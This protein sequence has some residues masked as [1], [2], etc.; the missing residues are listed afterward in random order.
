ME[1]EVH[2]LAPTIK[3]FF[4]L[5]NVLVVLAL[6]YFGGRKAIAAMIKARSEDIS[7]KIVDAKFE[8]ERIEHEADKARQEIASMEATRTR[9][10]EEVKLEGQ[11]TYD[12]LVVE[13]KSTAARILA[14]AKLATENELQLAILKVKEEVVLRAVQK[15]L[16]LAND[17]AHA[18]KRGQIHKKL[19]DQFSAQSGGNS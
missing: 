2:G 17:P 6:F 18:D 7:K 3:E 12:A 8:L 13:A 5:M 15:A 16:A 19:L 14:D 4:S 11:K 9:L 10:I 1:Q